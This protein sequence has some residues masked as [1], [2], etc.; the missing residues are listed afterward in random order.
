MKNQDLKSNR[1]LV[2]L[3]VSMTALAAFANKQSEINEIKLDERY[4]YG[5]YSDADEN[6]AYEGALAYFLLDVN[7]YRIDSG[8]KP[9]QTSDVVARVKTIKQKMGEKCYCMVYADYE[10]MMSIAPKDDDV[11]VEVEQTS[12]STVATTQEE[13]SEEDSLSISQGNSSFEITSSNENDDDSESQTVDYSEYNQI[14]TYLFEL[15]MAK[16]V[17]DNLKHFKQ[18]GMI[19][20][21]GLVDSSIVPNDALILVF[22]TE[23]GALVLKRIL[24]PIK[25]GK[26]V[27]ILTGHE[28][29]MLNYPKGQMLW[30]K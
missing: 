1:L 28:D 6:L 10:E 27:N 23:H 30:Y 24:S 15:K 14:N 25:D 7:S 16:D 2:L 20:D 22:E 12:I 17:I 3:L 9:L 26:R 18:K 21:M 13:D 5:E 8:Q 11:V 19:T 4:I 29:E